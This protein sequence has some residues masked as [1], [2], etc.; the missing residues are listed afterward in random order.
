MLK[1]SSG[2]LAGD[3]A[4]T[5]RWQ[6]SALSADDPVLRTAAHRAKEVGQ[7]NGWSPSTINCTIDGGWLQLRV[8]VGGADPGVADSVS[9]GPAHY[10]IS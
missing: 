7:T 9:H 2:E 4:V 1:T 6:H 3:R 10:R 5:P 8:L